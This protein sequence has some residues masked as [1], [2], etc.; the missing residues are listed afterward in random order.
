MAHELKLYIQPAYNYM[1]HKI[2]YAEILI[3]GYRGID[4]V[5]KILRFVE[6]NH[7]EGQFDLE[8]LEETLVK[9]K[10]YNKDKL[11]YAIGV[12]LCAFTPSIDGIAYKIINKIDSYGIMHENI[13]IEVNEYTDFDDSNV[14][15]NIK[16][17][18]DS[19]IK[20]ALDD[21]GVAMSNLSSL[22]HNNID[23]IK[24]DKSFIS[25]LASEEEEES[26]NEILRVMMDIC[27]AL[28]LKNIFEGI[29]TIHQLNI[30][31]KYGYTTVQGFLFNVPVPLDKFL[32]D[33]ADKNTTETPLDC[34][35]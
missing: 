12:N 18:R 35:G 31:K 30:I 25:K 29:E 5:S 9:M 2:E 28:K 22:M 19:G 24:V 1:T 17:L 10:K 3:R 26:R 32:R 33:G 34:C 20:I 21:F 6:K 11:K 7:I 14:R 27:N 8:V 15:S 23:I 13:I 16:I 4:N